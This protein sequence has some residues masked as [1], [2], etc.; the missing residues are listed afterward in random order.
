M[1][2]HH[3]KRFGPGTLIT[4]VALDLAGLAKWINPIREVQNNWAWAE[5]RIARESSSYI[6]YSAYDS[7]HLFYYI[8]CA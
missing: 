2:E 3:K 1:F 8:D 6:A 4:T 5:T 7:G